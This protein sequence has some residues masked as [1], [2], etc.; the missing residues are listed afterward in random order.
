M[1]AMGVQVRAGQRSRLGELAFHRTG[2]LNGIRCAQRRI[3]GVRGG[4]GRRQRRNIGVRREQRSQLRLCGKVRRA[5]VVGLDRYRDLFL[6]DAV[7]PLRLHDKVLGKAV[8]E[9][10]KAGADDGFRRG[11]FLPAQTP[12]KTQT[13]RPIAMVLDAVLG[14]KAQ[15][16][17]D[18]HIRTDLPVVFAVNPAIHK[19]VLGQRIAGKHGQLPR[20]A[21]LEGRQGIKR[22][23]A[24]KTLR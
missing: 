19:G 16:I 18:R 21:V 1:H 10:A 17:T 6:V 20:R 8:I 13:R 11:V 23:R 22:K 15:P 12:G 14:F 3:N 2:E 24:V 9:H 4:L 5:I 7:Q